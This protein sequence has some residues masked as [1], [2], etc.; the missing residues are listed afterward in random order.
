MTGTIT[1]QYDEVRLARWIEQQVEAAGIQV[2][3][4]AVMTGVVFESRRLRAIELA[5]RFGAARVEA[6]GFVDASGDA[7]LTYEAGLEVREPDAPVYGSLNFLSRAT[8]RRR[9]RTSSSRTCTRGSR[10][11]ARPTDW[12]ATTAS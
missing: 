6:N 9:S 11:A 12:S 5:T 7:S 10:S 8:T 2:L 1:F 4:G 3:V